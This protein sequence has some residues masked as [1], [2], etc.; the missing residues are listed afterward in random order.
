MD[1]IIFSGQSNMQGQTEAPPSP[2]DIV[3]GA[4]EYRYGT[5]ELIPLCHPC[6]EDI[7][8]ALLLAACDG[9]GSLV[10]DFCREYVRLTGRRV[11]AV[12]AARGGSEIREWLRDCGDAEDPRYKL[13][14]KRYKTL[15]AKINGAIA[16]ARETESVDR[17]FFLWLQGE[18]DAICRTPPEEYKRML[19]VFKDDLKADVGIERFGFIGVGYFA[20]T[21]RWLSDRTREQGM[22]DDEI[23]IR[24]QDELCREDEDFAMYTTVCRELSLQNEMISPYADGHYN[25]DAMTLIGK[26]AAR[27]LWARELGKTLET[28]RLILRPWREDD[29]EDC[30][31]YASDPRVGPIAGWKPHKDISETKAVIRDILC[32]PETYAVVWKETGEVIGSAGLMMHGVSDM[33]DRDDECELGYCI[34]VPWWGRGIMPEAAKEII[35]RAF[36]DLGM[37]A[38]WC[39]YYEGN[40]RSKRVQEKCG[41]AY[42]HTTRDLYVKQ[43]DERRTG[44]ANL[45]TREAWESAKE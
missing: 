26:Y 43:M 40:E 29:A 11:C 41:F 13:S 35:R 31:N 36:E 1:V 4:L 21:V 34:G 33:T 22:I 3:D 32:A 27:G 7:G 18:S 20:G 30:F 28:E 45:L 9:H 17:I 38:V 25:N 16:K 6:G 2:N 15:V 23:I 19:T 8:E 5:D 42:H 12:H 39:G 14:P 24:A 44:I 10:P 37:R